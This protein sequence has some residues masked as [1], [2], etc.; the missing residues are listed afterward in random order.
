MSTTQRYTWPAIV[1]HWAIALL[2]FGLFPLG[3][4]MS[5]LALSILKIK[6]FAWHKWFGLTVLLLAVLRL[7]WRAGHR[8]PPL[9]DSIPRWQQAAAGAL[10]WLLYLLIFAIPLSG[11][12]LSSAAGVQVVWFGVLPL[13]ELLPKDAATAH[14][15]REV[16]ESLNFLM[17]GVVALHVAAALKHHFIDRD[18]VL[19]RMLPLPTK[20]S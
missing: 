2:I 18:G 11:W 5:S 17:A 14:A 7:G 8:P 16:H 3:L 1:L 4:Y 13:P 19:R 10:H 9:P 15:L 12:A 20:E 6:L